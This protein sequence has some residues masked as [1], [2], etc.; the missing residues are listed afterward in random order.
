[1]Q[2]IGTPNAGGT[3]TQGGLT[4]SYAATPADDSSPMRPNMGGTISTEVAPNV[5]ATQSYPATPTKAQPAKNNPL[6]GAGTAGDQVDGS[7]EDVEDVDPGQ[8]MGIT[9]RGG[10]TP[11]GIDATG[12]RNMGGTGLMA[13]TF[14]SPKASSLYNDYVKRLGLA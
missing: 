3:I 6:S 1:M 11:A 10:T 14:S 2:R 7:V 5:T 13:R 12:S 9:Q 4:R 8:A